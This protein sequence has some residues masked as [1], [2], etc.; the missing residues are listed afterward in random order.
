MA[1]TNILLGTRKA[2]IQVI[3]DHR[4]VQG[5]VSENESMADQYI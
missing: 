2:C 4:Y 5:L 1:V 3:E